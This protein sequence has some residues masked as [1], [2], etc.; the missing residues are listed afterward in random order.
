MEETNKE[1]VR[2][3]RGTIDPELIN[4][5][6][7]A[8]FKDA[9]RKAI[10]G[11][12]MRHA[13]DELH[14]A[15]TNGRILLHTILDESDAGLMGAPEFEM[16]VKITRRLKA[17]KLGLAFWAKDGVVVFRGP[18]VFDCFEIS[19]EKFPE[20][21][22]CEIPPEK[23]EPLTQW[24]SCDPRYLKLVMDYVGEREYI[25]PWT[26]GDCEGPVVFTGRDEKSGAKKTA[27]LMPL[28]I[29]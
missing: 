17:T 5:H 10:Q 28:R 26:R 2:E 3:I 6:M 7:R 1:E 15:T 12:Y 11:L 8:A 24:R 4:L 14:L 29:A 20:F 25:T 21:E 9:D 22:H 27:T 18:G 13:R 19:S 23:L 16:V